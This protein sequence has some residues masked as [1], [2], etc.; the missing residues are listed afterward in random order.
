MNLLESWSIPGICVFCGKASWLDTELLVKV[1]GIQNI[2]ALYLLYH[3]TSETSYVTN[4]ERSLGNIYLD[5]KCFGLRLF[6]LCPN[7]E[8]HFI[9]F[10]EDSSAPWESRSAPR[11]ARGLVAKL[12]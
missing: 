7:F 10:I 6:R 8:L 11:S 4:D 9:F 2:S 3:T 12:P 1:R 5:D